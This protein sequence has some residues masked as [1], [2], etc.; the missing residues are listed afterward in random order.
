MTRMLRL[1]LPEAIP[2]GVEVWQLKLNLSRRI[3][4]TDFSLLSKDERARALYFYRHEDRVRAIAT[5]AALRRLLAERL[6]SPAD[7]IC[8][9]ANQYG[10]P[11]LRHEE[12]IEFNVSHA[13]TF[14]LIALSINGP[15]GVD[16]ECRNRGVEAKMLNDYVLSSLER[17][18]GS[19]IADFIEHWVAKESALKALGLG[20]SEY[21]QAVSI[22]PGEGSDYRVIH[23]QPEWAGLKVWPINAPDGYAAAVAVKAPHKGKAA[24]RERS[25][26]PLE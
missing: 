7:E 4:S 22:L 10:K 24:L 13:G 3:S 5:R 2:S 26:T 17:R 25:P 21:L 18:S 12:D 1:P 23:D 11:F 16:I 9:V 6:A 19:G 20:I 8:F 15:V 14:S